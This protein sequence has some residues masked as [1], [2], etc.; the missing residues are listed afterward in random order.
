MDERP[1]WDPIRAL[2]RRVIREDAPL[3]LT[4][5]V[6][7]LLRRS[8][9]EVAI[10]DADAEQ[11]LATEAGATELLREIAKRITEGSNRLMDALHRMYRHQK[12]GDFGS[13]RQEMR[14]VLDV[15][16]VPFYRETAREQLEEMDDKP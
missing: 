9:R 2:A 11:A 7:T 12:A 14:D 15:E 5:E 3:V 13:A 6:R 4:P 1:D 16:V 10:R 8:A